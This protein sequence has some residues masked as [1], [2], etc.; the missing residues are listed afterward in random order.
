MT[1][2]VGDRVKIAMDSEHY[3]SYRSG[4][5]P[6]VGGVVTEKYQMSPRG[7]EYRVLWDNGKDNSYRLTD[8]VRES[9]VL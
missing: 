9:Y 7:Y 2:K 8:L 4:N 3:T 1:F 5:N 6:C